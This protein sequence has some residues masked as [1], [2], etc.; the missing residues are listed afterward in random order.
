MECLHCYPP[1]QMPA[2]VTGCDLGS[3]GMQRIITKVQSFDRQLRSNLIAIANCAAVCCLCIAIYWLVTELTFCRLIAI[4]S[5]LTVIVV[6]DWLIAAG[7]YQAS[8]D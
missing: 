3:C 1:T 6:Q 7:C 5:V 8:L 4:H 2:D